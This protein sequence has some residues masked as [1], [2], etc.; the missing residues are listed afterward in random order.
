LA[1]TV[2][3]GCN[4]AGKAK[5]LVE[6]AQLPANKGGWKVGAGALCRSC[7]AVGSTYAFY[8]YLHIQCAINA[9]I[10]QYSRTHDL[11]SSLFTEQIHSVYRI[12]WC[13]RREQ[14]RQ[15]K[16]YCTYLGAVYE[17]EERK[18]GRRQNIK[19]EKKKKKKS[20]RRARKVL[21]ASQRVIRSEAGASSAAAAAS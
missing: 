6:Y 4:P 17:A 20:K 14:T 9:F 2:L 12:L 16:I 10:I 18:E 19:K 1:A 7:P 11:F 13:Y 21:V 3:I 5:L 8:L 15:N